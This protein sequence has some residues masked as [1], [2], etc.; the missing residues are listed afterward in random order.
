MKTVL[1][2]LLLVMAFAV[3]MTLPGCFDFNASAFTASASMAEA[4]DISRMP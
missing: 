4:D 2:A 3:L 1:M